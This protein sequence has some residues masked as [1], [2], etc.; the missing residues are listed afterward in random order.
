IWQRIPPFARARR[1]ERRSILW[2]NLALL[3]VIVPLLLAFHAVPALLLHL[4]LLAAAA[5]VGSWLF[6]VQHQFEDTYWAPKD[7][8]KFESAALRGSSYYRLPRLLQWFSG[9]I[10][11]HH[12]HHYSSRIPN[13]HLERAHEGVAEF[14][15]SPTLG[16]WRSLRT[17]SLVLWD[18]DARRLVSF[19]TARRRPAWWQAAAA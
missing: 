15:Q 4:T 13:Y 1:V 7:G 9:N 14:R 10:G 19:R 2:T 16:F 8:W 5:S 11:F 6:Y 12:V 17:I 18:E 3:M